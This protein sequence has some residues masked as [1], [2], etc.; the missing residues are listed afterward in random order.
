MIKC[1]FCNQTMEGP[2]SDGP[3]VFADLYRCG[4]CQVEQ[5]IY[6]EHGERLVSMEEEPKE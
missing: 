4:A 2:S 5:A 6:W 3:S 1:P